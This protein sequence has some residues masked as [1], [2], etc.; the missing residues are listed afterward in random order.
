MFY[1][2][3]YVCTHMCLVHSKED[4]ESPGAGIM[5]RSGCWVLC[6]GSE[7]LQLQPS[8]PAFRPLIV[9]T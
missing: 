4:M 6:K 9:E 7:H 3:E 5:G 8:P 2:Y 1:L